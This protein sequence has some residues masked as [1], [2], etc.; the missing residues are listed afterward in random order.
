[1]ATYEL[2]PMSL[3][4]IL[5]G[6]FT[7]LGRHFGKLFTLAVVCLAIPMALGVYVES[8]GGVIVRPGLWLLAQLLGLLGYLL[9]SGATVFVVSETYLG[10]PASA[11][12]A[13]RFAVSKMWPIFVVFVAT[14]IILALSFFPAGLAFWSSFMLFGVGGG[15]TLLAG[16]LLGMLLCLLPLILMAGYAVVVQAVVLEKLPSATRSLGRSW[17]LTKGHRVKVV[18]LWVVIGVLFAAVVIGIGL[19][20]GFPGQPGGGQVASNALINLAMMLIYPLSSCIFTLLY[21]DL[22]VRKEAFD[23]ELLSRQIGLAP[24]EA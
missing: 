14:T 12:D 19:V 20:L 2:R 21:Y 17:S 4:E 3:G 24:T 13:L 1:M 22:R 9:V 8:A 7:L 10:R 6:A 18:L 15:P 16:L 11:R 23:L 5:D